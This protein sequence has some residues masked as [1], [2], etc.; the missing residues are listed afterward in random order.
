MHKLPRLQYISSGNSFQEQYHHIC[1]AL[2]AGIE[3]IQIRWKNADIHQLQRL[4]EKV[5]IQCDSYGAICI[6]NDY[7]EIARQVHATGVHLGLE[8]MPVAQARQIILP[9]QWIGGTA[10]TLSDV[11][12]RIEEKVTYIGL[13]PLRYTTTKSQLSPI[14]GWEG[15]QKIVSTLHTHDIPIYA[16]GGVTEKDIEFLISIGIYGVAM[17]S[18][19]QKASD[20]YTY[21]QHLNSLLY[22]STQNSR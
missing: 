14:L 5:K 11:Q 10:N 13:G 18:A 9:H 3:W 21:I 22:G 4:A 16:I 19:I 1:K 6:I 15:Y 8:D 20:L 17:S 7:P 2:D 12:K